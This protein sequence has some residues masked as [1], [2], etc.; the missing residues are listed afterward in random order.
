MVFSSFRS[1]H[2]SCLPHPLGLIFFQNSAQVPVVGASIP[3]ESM[4]TAIFYREGA[5]HPKPDFGPPEVIMANTEVVDITDDY[6]WMERARALTA[7]AYLQLAD[8]RLGLEVEDVMP[9]VSADFYEQ[10]GHARTFA[11][12][13]TH[14]EVGGKTILGLGRVVVGVPSGED[15]PIDAMSFVEPLEGWP[16]EKAGWH[17]TPIA[18]FGRFMIVAACRTPTAREAGLHAWVCRRI[19]EGL[20][21]VARRE[22]ARGV[23]AVLPP[24]MVRLVKQAGIEIREI[25]S[26]LRTEDP[27]AAKVFDQFSLYWHHARPK[28]YELADA[29][30][31][32]PNEYVSSAVQA[33]AE[34]A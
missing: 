7:E 33:F 30:G 6:L 23:Y 31:L 13:M 27:F 9:I 32:E 25:E 28:L 17:A 22:H 24:Y 34:Y 8:P 15:P 14:P 18:E 21:S 12:L 29:P 1:L 11:A 2:I 10:H 5:T 16:H 19:Y 26:R 20:V 4:N 3:K